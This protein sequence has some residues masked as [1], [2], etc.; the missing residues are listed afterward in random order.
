MAVFREVRTE[1]YCDT[2][3]ELLKAWKQLPGVSKEWAKYFARQEGATTG[4]RIKCKKCRIRERIERCSLIKKY[5]NP[6]KDNG[7]CLGYG[8][9]FDDEPIEKCKRCIACTS[10]DWEEEAYRLSI[11]AKYDKRMKG[12]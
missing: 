8:K 6:G 10:F 11:G 9:E 3:G 2:C 4:K 5:G 7:A 12:R 1:V